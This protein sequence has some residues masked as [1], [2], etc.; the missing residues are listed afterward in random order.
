MK[1]LAKEVCHSYMSFPACSINFLP[2]VWNVSPQI[3]VPSSM[4][5]F[6]QQSWSLILWH[7]IAHKL[8]FKFFLVVLFIITIKRELR[9]QLLPVNGLLLWQVW[10]WSTVEECEKLGDFELENLL[11]TVN[12]AYLANL[13]GLCF[14]SSTN[15]THWYSVLMQEEPTAL[16]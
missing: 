1:R 15:I 11:N 8:S 13:R 7:H 12:R 9:Q 10:S 16:D 3:A 4:P 2:A 14:V 5:V 6:T